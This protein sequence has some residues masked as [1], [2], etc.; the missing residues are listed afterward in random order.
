MKT[1]GSVHFLNH[2]FHLGYSLR[3]FGLGITLDRYSLNIDIA[4]FWIS[5]EW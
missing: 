5:F 1:F 2:R 4:F 3:R